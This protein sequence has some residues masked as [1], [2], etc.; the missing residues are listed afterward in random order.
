MED[1]MKKTLLLVFLGLFLLSFASSPGIAQDANEV[2]KKMIDAMGGRKVLES[3]RDSTLTGTWE[4]TQMGMSGSLTMYMKE[5]NKMR[6]DG[7]IQGMV[8]TMAYDGETAWMINPQT[9]GKEDMPEDQAESFKRGAMGND[10]LLDPAK[11]GIS[12]ADKGKET[13]NNKDYIVLEETYS[14]GYKTTLYIDPETN[15][16]Y[17][18]KSKS[19]GPGGTEVE[20]ES[21][22][23][24]YRKIDG[25]MTAHSITIT[26]GGQE[27]MRMAFTS[28]KFNTGLE[29]SLFKK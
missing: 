24:D 8:I 6:W 5:P 17:K 10:T 7:E 15:L 28:V 18:A 27:Y 4:M 1:I 16:P 22:M 26:Q 13:I 25:V 11:F 29:D 3:V 21:F 19:M 12:F 9:G 2:L 20:S 14:D 23:S